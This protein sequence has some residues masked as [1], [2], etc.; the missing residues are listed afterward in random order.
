MEDGFG[1]MIL[2][3]YAVSCDNH[4]SMNYVLEFLNPGGYLRQEFSCTE[5]GA[6]ALAACPRARR[7]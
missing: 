1:D 2:H 4:L 6:P 7:R 3:V 5:Q